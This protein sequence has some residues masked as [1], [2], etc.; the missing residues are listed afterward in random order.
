M[1]NH[2][3]LALYF[4]LEMHRH[5]SD[6]L[7]S[8]NLVDFFPGHSSEDHILMII[9]TYNAGEMSSSNSH[10][11]QEISRV[12]YALVDLFDSILRS[13]QIQPR[14]PLQEPR[15]N[16]IVKHVRIDDLQDTIAVTIDGL[17]SFD[18]QV[19]RRAEQ[20]VKKV[21]GTWGL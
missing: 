15:A 8:F 18:P 7:N 19:F 17:T 11:R 5:E 4:Q 14:W 2:E 13:P 16:L 20:R 9:Q 3:Y 10:L 12:G 1:S 6:R 21:G